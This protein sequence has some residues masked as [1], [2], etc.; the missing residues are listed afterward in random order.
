MLPMDRMLPRP[1]CQ[2]PSPMQMWNLVRGAV[3]ALSW[4]RWY[5]AAS[6]LPDVV[7][8]LTVGIL[9]VPQ[10]ARQCACGPCLTAGLA[11]AV[12][13]RLPP[14]YGLYTSVTAPLVYMLFGQSREL[15]I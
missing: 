9:L 4:L 15:S 6:A 8:G 13:G 2:R 3:P 14:V 7:A 12:V 5:K 11:Y 1:H 10:G